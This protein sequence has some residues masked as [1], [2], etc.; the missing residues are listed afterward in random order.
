LTPSTASADRFGWARR[1]CV[2]EEIKIKVEHLVAAK[3]AGSPPD[4]T[5]IGWVN[6]RPDDL[7]GKLESVGLVQ[8]RA[9]ANMKLTAFV[10]DYISKRVDI[11]P[12][13][14]LN[15]RITAKRMTE[16]FGKERRLRDVTAGD[17]DEFAAWLKTIHAAATVSRTLRRAIQFYKAAVK[18]GFVTT[19]PFASIKCGSQVNSARNYFVNRDDSQKVMDACPSLEWRLIF[20]LCRFG[21]LRCPSEHRRLRWIDIDWETDRIRVHSPK[22]EHLPGGGVR[23]VPIFPELRALLLESAE[24]AP[25]GAVNVITKQNLRTEFARIV[26]RA[27]LKLWPRLFQNLRASRETELA[28]EFPLHVVC[29]WIGNSAKIAAAHYLSVSD[30]DFKRAAA[31]SGAESGAANVEMVQKQVQ[32]D[33]APTSTT[34]QKNEKTPTNFGVSRKSLGF[35]AISKSN[36]TPRLGLEA[37]TEGLRP[38]GGHKAIAL[39]A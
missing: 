33:A 5:L 17:A 6:D 3:A 32:H 4:P 9:D 1:P 31:G 35:S 38:P 10:A 11:K 20:A 29:Q 8:G 15:L 36:E 30:D 12:Q 26:E 39:K 18:K 2:A 13:T 37:R 24:Q 16:F 19:N 7:H 25:E 21:G 23:Y 27:G 28:G 22:K 14:R 34:T